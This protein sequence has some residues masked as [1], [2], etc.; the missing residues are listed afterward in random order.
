MLLFVVSQNCYV[1]RFALSDALH[2]DCYVLV[3]VLSAVAVGRL[4]F[5]LRN[6]VPTF[7]RSFYSFLSRWFNMMR[8][9]PARLA[10]VDERRLQKNMSDH[11]TKVNVSSSDSL[12]DRKELLG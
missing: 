10:L 4:F 1:A 7:S 12:C 5:S 11:Q 9:F 3:A 2:V 6:R 8:K